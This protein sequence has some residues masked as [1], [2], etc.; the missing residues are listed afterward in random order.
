MKEVL[1]KLIINRTTVF[2]W[3]EV[4]AWETPVKTVNKN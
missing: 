4:T 3:Y 1:T 2:T